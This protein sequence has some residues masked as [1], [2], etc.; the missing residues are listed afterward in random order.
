MS[1]RVVPKDSG[2]TGFNT[3]YQDANQVREKM[4]MFGILIF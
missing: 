4:Q 3:Q 2:L 1:E